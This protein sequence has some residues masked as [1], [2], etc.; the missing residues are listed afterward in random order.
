MALRNDSR[1]DDQLRPFIIE[2]GYASAAA[3]S[4]MVQAGQTVVLCTAS[5]AADLPPW[6]AGKGKGWVTAEYSMLPGST[7]PRKPRERQKTDGRTTEIQRLIG[8]SLR[9]VVDLEALGERSVTVDCDVIRADGGTRTA[10]ITGAFV[11]LVDAV[12]S[13][14][15]DPPTPSKVFRDS[16]AAVSVGVVGGRVLLDLN[17]EEDFAAAVDMNVVMTGSGRFVEVQGTGEEATFSA[18]EL[19]QLVAAGQRGVDQL[20]ALQRDALGDE[21]PWA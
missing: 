8:R 15:I 20:T 18:E 1:R 6:M 16:L 12:Q 19:Q 11:A 9:A 2:R 13:I 7:A 14:E 3:G 10:S 4:V 5:V 17:Y 21:W